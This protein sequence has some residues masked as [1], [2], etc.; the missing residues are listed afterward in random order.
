MENLVVKNDRVKLGM[1]ST[2]SAEGQ[3]DSDP[4]KTWVKVQNFKKNLNF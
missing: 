4:K 3:L 1:D 2:V